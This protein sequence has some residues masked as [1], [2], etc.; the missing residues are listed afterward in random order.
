MHK[1]FA[2]PIRSNGASQKVSS[3]NISSSL[4][5][6]NPV[7][8]ASAIKSAGN[9]SVPITLV[10][11]GSYFVEDPEASGASK[12]RKSKLILKKQASTT[13]TLRRKF[14]EL[15][16]RSEKDPD[17]V[18]KSKPGENRTVFVSVVSRM[19]VAPLCEFFPRH[20]HR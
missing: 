15:F 13:S 6:S 5:A 14:S 17:E 7:A 11:L 10:V 1:P 3:A 20:R 19:I 8:F 18:V 4:S 2:I 9:C 16:K 12:P